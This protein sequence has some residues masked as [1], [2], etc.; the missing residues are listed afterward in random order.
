MK[1]KQSFFRICPFRHILIVLSILIIALHLLLRSGKPQMKWISQHVIRPLHRTLSVLTAGVP[2]SVAEFLIAL[3]VI[4]AIIYLVWQIIAM[5]RR[6]E[7][8]KRLYK[9]VITYLTAGLAIYAGFCLL[10]GTFYYGDDFITA[11]GLKKEKISV[12]QLS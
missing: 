8:L 11:S 7:R 6:P 5:V 1:T 9:T 10:W 2:F 12:E 4:G 3:L